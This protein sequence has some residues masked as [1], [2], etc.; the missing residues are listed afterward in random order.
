MNCPICNGLV[1]GLLSGMYS[2][3]YR[4]IDCKCLFIIWNEVDEDEVDED[5]L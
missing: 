1:M 4:C 2:N 5:E 3:E